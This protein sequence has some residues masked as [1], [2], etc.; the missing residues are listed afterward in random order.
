MLWNNAPDGPYRCPICDSTGFVCT[1]HRDRP[2]GELSTRADACGC[3]TGTP[4]RLCNADDPV[5][6]LE[7]NVIHL[8]GKPR[9]GPRF[10]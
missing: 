3:S 1:H 5:P 10:H 4:C 2:W 8:N 6:R 9:S 7:S